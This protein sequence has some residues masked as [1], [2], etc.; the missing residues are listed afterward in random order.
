MSRYLCCFAEKVIFPNLSEKLGRHEEWFADTCAANL[1]H[2]HAITSASLSTFCEIIYNFN[3]LYH[4]SKP[5]I[6]L[7]VEPIT[8]QNLEASPK[9]LL[10]RAAALQLESVTMASREPEAKMPSPSL[11]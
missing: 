8:H 1:F 4:I 7:S 2:P 6:N 5:R 10:P 3:D 9:T 11:S